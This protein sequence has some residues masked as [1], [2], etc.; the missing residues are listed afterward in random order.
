M[1][2]I[3]LIE[4]NDILSECTEINLQRNIA[5]AMVRGVKS[6]ASAREL[7]RETPPDVAIVD[8]NLADGDGLTLI[9]P[10]FNTNPSCVV[11]VTSGMISPALHEEVHARGVW[12]VL[13]KPYEMAELN[14]AIT[15]GLERRGEQATVVKAPSSP[16]RPLESLQLDAA[17]RATHKV[18]N[19]LSSLMTGLRL[20][21]LEIDEDLV[22]PE[23]RKQEIDHSIDRM[24]EVVRETSATVREMC[25]GDGDE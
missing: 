13:A 17:Q 20:L 18:M 4:D 19:R 21:Q 24:I 5:G 12:R 8:C 1:P 2:N 25:R 10:L 15:Q 7:L 11:I 9:E 6:L 16:S 22:G 23:Q 3:L 14:D